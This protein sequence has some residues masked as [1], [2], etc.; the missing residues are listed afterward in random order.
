MIDDENNGPMR[1]WLGHYDDT[2]EWFIVLA[3]SA[4]R[5]AEEAD[6][7]GVV[8]PDSIVPFE[9]EFLVCFRGQW[10][11]GEDGPSP[12][13][14]VEANEQE[15][16]LGFD[17]L[18]YI[19]KTIIERDGQPPHEDPMVEK[20]DN[21]KASSEMKQKESKLFSTEEKETEYI[22]GECGFRNKNLS[23]TTEHFTS[24]HNKHER[25]DIM[26]GKAQT[27]NEKRRMDWETDIGLNLDDVSKQM[28]E[29]QDD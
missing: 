10:L 26:I 23:K 6:Q 27:R 12:M 22:C 16:E 25:I 14:Y 19:E 21:E 13:M 2:Y 5:A 20:V 11:W 29:D 18:S 17:T 24:V 7:A 4:E 3:D 15:L 8:D 9:D 1:L 28:K